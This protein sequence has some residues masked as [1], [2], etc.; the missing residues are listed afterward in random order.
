MA[1]QSNPCLFHFQLFSRTASSLR[2]NQ[3]FYLPPNCSSYDTTSHFLVKQQATIAMRS[4]RGWSQPHVHGVL[5]INI[6]SPK[7]GYIMCGF[8]FPIPFWYIYALMDHANTSHFFKT[9]GFD[10]TCKL[11]YNTVFDLLYLICICVNYLLKG[12]VPS[13]WLAPPTDRRGRAPD[14]R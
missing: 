14:G 8:P 9:R 10:H 6:T 2:L 3:F 1:C 7:R 5:G 4:V 11:I 13:H 12:E